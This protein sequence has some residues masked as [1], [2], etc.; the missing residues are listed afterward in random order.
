L[1][2][3]CGFGGVLS[4]RLSTSSSL[5]CFSDFGGFAMIDMTAHAYEVI[6]RAIIAWGHFEQHMLSQIWVSRK[7]SAFY[8]TA[9]PQGFSKRWIEW[10]NIHRPYAASLSDFEAFLRHVRDLSDFRDDIAHNVHDISYNH[11]GD[12]FGLHVFRITPDWETKFKRW[13]GKFA[14]LPW[15]GRP[16]APYTQEQIHYR[17]SDVTKF[18]SNTEAAL[19]RLKEIGAALQSAAKSSRPSKPQTH[20]PP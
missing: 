12:D 10:C 11:H 4:I 5:D 13:A 17:K 6:G 15:Q 1:I 19:V 14:H 9:L 2:G 16:P 7:P 8:A 20:G 18:I 3:L